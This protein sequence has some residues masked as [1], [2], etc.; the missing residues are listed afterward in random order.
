MSIVYAIADTHLGHKNIA[1]YRTQFATAEEHDECVLSML[2]KTLTKNDKIYFLGDIAF[3]K[4][5]LAKIDELVGQKILVPGNHCT[6]YV[7]MQNIVKV[8]KHV[9]SLTTYKGCWL[10]HAPIHPDELRGRYN[11]HGHV[12]AATLPDPRYFNV[13]CENINFTP[14]DFRDI[15]EEL[16]YRNTVSTNVFY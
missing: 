11:V 3:S 4:E 15:K 6:E 8:Y 7:H 10:S 12:H 2:R 13:S 5:S 9:H 14:M 1:K 16:L